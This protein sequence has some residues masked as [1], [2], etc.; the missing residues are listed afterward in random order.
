V[1]DMAADVMKI[2]TVI[3]FVIALAVTGLTLFT[4]TL[5]KLR[6]YGI[7][8]ALGASARRLAAT[9]IVQA[10]WSIGLALILAVALAMA[11]GAGISAATPNV[12]IAIEP[13]SIVRTGG[14]A[15]VVGALAS[16][17]PLRRVQRI[18][19]ATAFRRP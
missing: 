8:K 2:V 16:L 17:I 11:I 15:L 12:R 14:T 7:L 18:D 19:P 3:G 4:A 1:R 10:A 5:P 9:V 6:E 13:A